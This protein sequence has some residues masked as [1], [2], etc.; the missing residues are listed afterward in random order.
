M[1]HQRYVEYSHFLG[2][3]GISL[4]IHILILSLSLFLLWLDTTQSRHIIH[5]TFLYN[6]LIGCNWWYNIINLHCLGDTTW[7][8]ISISIDWW[9]GGGTSW[10]WWILSFMIS[11]SRSD[12]HCIK[13]WGRVE[14]FFGWTVGRVIPVYGLFFN[15]LCWRW[16]WW[17][18]L[19]VG[20]DGLATA[21]CWCY[22]CIC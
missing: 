5:N 2:L 22:C 16:Y 1:N 17:L 8:I 11:C 18:L 13:T 9:R 7:Y 15:F 3:K 12:C 14:W 4:R 10:L 21:C 20:G 6:R 19:I